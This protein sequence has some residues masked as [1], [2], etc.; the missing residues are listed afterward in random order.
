MKAVIVECSNGA[1]VAL[2][3][4]GTFRKLKNKGYSIGQ[5]LLIRQKQSSNRMVQKLSICASLALVLLSF[6]GIGSHSYVEPYSYVSLDINP[7]IEYALNRY[8]KVISVSGVNTEGQQI[9]SSIESDIKNQNITTALGVTIGQLEKDHY[10]SQKAYNHV[11][12][13]VYSAN[14]TKAQSITSR[15]NTLSAEKSD[16]C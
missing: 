13:S 10:I 9:V 15:V 8:D 5:E 3:D 11:I 16:L 14:D 4:D 1:A 6:A 7:S 12:V 2:C